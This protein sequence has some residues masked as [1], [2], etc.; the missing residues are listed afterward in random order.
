MT[1]VKTGGRTEQSALQNGVN[2]ARLFEKQI[3][4]SVRAADQTLLYVRG[5]YVRDPEHFDFSFCTKNSQFLAEFTLQVSRPEFVRAV[6][7]PELRPSFR[8]GRFGKPHQFRTRNN[9]TERT[10]TNAIKTEQ[11]HREINEAARSPP[12]HNGL[13]VVSA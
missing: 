4:R 10:V 6:G 9:A 12:A 7:A 8:A 11:K 3:I 13:V 5:S 1:S 2:L